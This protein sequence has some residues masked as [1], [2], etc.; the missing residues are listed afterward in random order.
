[1][2][3]VVGLTAA[4]V[5]AGALA[6][7]A[8][9]SGIPAD[10]RR[11][12]DEHY[13]GRMQAIVDEESGEVRTFSAPAAMYRKIDINGDR[14]PDWRVDY[15]K[16]ENASLFCGTGGCLQQLYLARP[17]GGFDLVLNTNL[18]LFRMSKVRGEH[19]LDLDFHGSTCG[20][21]GFV[22]CPRSYGW[23]SALGRYIERPTSKGLTWLSGG[24]RQ[25]VEDD[26]SAFP[27]AVRAEIERQTAIC[28]NAGSRVS[29][30]GVPANDLP[31]LNGDGVRDW[32]VGSQYGFC[33]R[34][35]DQQAGAF[36]PIVILASRDGGFKPAWEAMDASWGV[37]LG[38]PARLVTLEGEH[39]G[40]TQ[41]VCTRVLWS[42]D[43]ERF[44][45]P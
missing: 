28:A 34:G 17:D 8:A 27:P 23:N 11:T 32:V 30:G 12:V 42:W 6:A 33:D 29:E 44:V 18:R 40:I 20:E 43:G 37:D 21:A 26:P 9:V 13:S 31:D 35:D 2:R 45:R 38:A 3:L 4:V 5:S 24:P 41:E 39:C 1:M 19:V 7:A 36:L 25:L 10:L 15:E 22:E 14:L 16:A